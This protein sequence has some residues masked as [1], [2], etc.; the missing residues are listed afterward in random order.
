MIKSNHNDIVTGPAFAVELISLVL[1]PNDLNVWSSFAAL[2]IDN[3][4]N[5]DNILYMCAPF[6]IVL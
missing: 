5:I 3:I 4:D 6:I 1:K 2:K